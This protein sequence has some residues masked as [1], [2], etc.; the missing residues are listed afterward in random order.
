VLCL[1]AGG[2]APDGERAQAERLLEEQPAA[3]DVCFV[4]MMVPHHAQAVEMSEILLDKPGVWERGRKFAEYVAL[5]QGQ[6]VQT[7]TAWLD[8]WERALAS[9]QAITEGS[10]PRVLS[11]A[12]ARH[13]DPGQA[14]TSPLPGCT[15]GHDGHGP[16]RESG[17]PGMLS[18]DELSQLRQA[19]AASAQRQ[20]LELMVSHHEGAL[21]MARD[22]METGSNDYVMSLAN[23]VVVE[24][25][26]EIAALEDM[27][28]TLDGTV[29]P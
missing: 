14:P 10:G 25:E 4:R 24:Q 29:R 19:D 27:L 8:A 6:E 26:Q 20:Y 13:D 7:M 15:N 23:H 3:A 16:H 22:V 12:H 2:C 21:E 11:D 17:M 28:A 5:A 1:A 9:A 18:R